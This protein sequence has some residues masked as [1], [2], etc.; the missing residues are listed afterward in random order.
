MHLQ[1]VGA[2]NCVPG[3]V[4]NNC[5]PRVSAHNPQSFIWETSQREFSDCFGASLLALHPRVDSAETALSMQ[6]AGDD[7]KPFSRTLIYQTY[8]PRSSRHGLAQSALIR[9]FTSITG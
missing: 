7:V 4:R 1:V 6:N 2:L 8:L 9:I 5:S 3:S